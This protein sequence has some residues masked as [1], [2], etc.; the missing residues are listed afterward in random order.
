MM[1]VRSR[2]VHVLFPLVAHWE[3]HQLEKLSMYKMDRCEV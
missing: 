3:N 1:M 2:L